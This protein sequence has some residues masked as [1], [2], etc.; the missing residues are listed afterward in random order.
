MNDNLL[1]AFAALSATLG[2]SAPLVNR[3]QS[4]LSP[5]SDS[6]QSSPCAESLASSDNSYIFVASSRDV[7]VSNPAVYVQNTMYQENNED[8][9]GRQEL[10]VKMKTLLSS[11][12]PQTK[13]TMPRTCVLR[14]PGGMGKTQAA[15]HY[16]HKNKG[17]FD[18]ALW[19]QANN[20]ESLLAGY[21]Q[22]AV[23]LGLHTIRNKSQQPENNPKTLVEWL[24]N[25]LERP[26]NPR[27]RKLDWL[28]VFD[29]LDDEGVL[30]DFWP[31]GAV[32]SVIITTRDPMVSGIKVP[33]DGDLNVERL[34]EAEAVS[35][36][37]SKTPARLLDA[38]TEET[39][40]R[41]VQ[42]LSCWPIVIVQIAGKME[43]L[44]Q[45]P[46]R[47]LSVYQNPN[48]RY[49]YYD[50]LERVE[51]GYT[52]PLSSLWSLKE[53]HP[54][55]A[56]ILSVIS[57]L[58]PDSIPEF[59]LEDT[60]SVANLDGYPTAD[61]YDFAI[62][63]LERHSMVV[64]ASSTSLGRGREIFSHSVIQEV[65]RAQLMMEAPALVEVFNSTVRLLMGFWDFQSVPTTR[66]RE[67]AVA[68]K[69]RW[70]RCNILLPHMHHMRSIFELLPPDS[71]K[72]CATEMWFYMM[73]EAGW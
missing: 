28:I 45:T 57:L 30:G 50:K 46:S 40:V 71:K 5:S 2:P 13:L 37:R 24:Q 16:F 18:V 51:D 42:V 17:T 26:S 9:Q 62:A 61:E 69:P 47:F 6:S 19:M 20:R 12:S 39:L 52:I 11:S 72:A 70:E 7:M 4:L 27:S 49:H 73:N 25:P 59:V 8:F 21:T 1:K 34:S 35:L 68:E 10:I 43:R 60:G 36:L 58:L 14:G 44:N 22:A 56:R 55:A 53:L 41:V 15:L 67:P 23:R 33:R 32:G 54:P 29:N 66:Y 3:Q 38:E 63:Q 65:I 64:R 48:T 31:R